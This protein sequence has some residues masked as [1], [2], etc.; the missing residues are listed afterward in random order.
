MT[1]SSVLMV[2]VFTAFATTHV[3]ADTSFVGSGATRIKGVSA[4][5]KPPVVIRALE[6]NGFKC[7]KNDDNATS[8]S[9]FGYARCGPK[10][11]DIGYAIT[12]G[13]T[14]AATVPSIS[15]N[16]EMFDGCKKS[17]TQIV[18]YLEL[19]Y[20]LDFGEIGHSFDKERNYR[21]AKD[22]SGQSVCVLPELKMLNLS[23][24]FYSDFSL[25]LD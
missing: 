9:A 18:K 5:M 4:F 22:R 2:V 25:D 3:L 19:K 23:A 10:G 15:F 7:F 11:Q 16:C 1:V 24:P 6:K 13:V 20:R 14:V 21:C 12:A 8:S 17:P